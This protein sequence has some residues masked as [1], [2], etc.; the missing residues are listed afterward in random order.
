MRAAATPRARHAALEH[1]SQDRFTGQRRGWTVAKADPIRSLLAGN[2]P[3][4][5]SVAGR[6]AGVH[7]G[8]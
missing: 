6:R 1:A 2:T 5:Q 8:Q 4:D 3:P 7:R